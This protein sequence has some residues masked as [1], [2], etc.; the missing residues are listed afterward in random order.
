[1]NFKFLHGADLHLDSPLLGLATKSADYAERVHRASREAFEAMIAFAIAEECRFV[2]LAGDVFDGDLRNF[3]TGLFFI[4]QMRRLE[5]AG[6]RVFMVLGNHDAENRFVRKLALSPNVHVFD[7]RRA[8]TITIDDLGVAI[9]GRSFPQREVNENIARDYPAASAGA[10]N[11]GVLHTACQGSEDYHAP[12]AP[13]S[14][15]QLVNHG[16]DYWALGHVHQRS[17]L[18]EAPHIVYPGNLQGRSPRETG[19]KGA[20]LVGVSD[21]RVTSLEH[22]DFDVVRWEALSVDVA[23]ADTATNILEFVRAAVQSVYRT[24]GSRALALRLRITGETKLHSQLLLEL[25]GLRE[26]VIALLATIASD[27]WLEKLRLDTAPPP[28]RASIDPSVAGRIAADVAGEDND[29]RIAELLDTCLADVRAKMPAAAHA[30][31]FFEILKAEAPA[32]ARALALAVI[33]DAEGNNA[34]H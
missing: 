8:E 24:I 15:E 3:E 13:C 19:P 18:A 27:I 17:V 11:I 9:H 10:F 22:Q 5:E 12:Y 29:A 32:R 23:G 30:E 25:P 6:V 7:S 4:E 1:M 20:T 2:L 33:K 31:S 16:Y 28:E 21:G 14:I 26:D 34:V